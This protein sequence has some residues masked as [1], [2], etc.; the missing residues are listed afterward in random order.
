MRPHI[1]TQ[2]LYWLLLHSLA[3]F[4]FSVSVSDLS[5][6]GYGFSINFWQQKYNFSDKVLLWFLDSLVLL[7]ML[8]YFKNH[9]LRLIILQ[10]F[11]CSIFVPRMTRYWPY[12]IAKFMLFRHYIM[13]G[14]NQINLYQIDLKLRIIETEQIRGLWSVNTNLY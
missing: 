8:L 2:G 5:G 3:N 9:N 14:F 10:Y 11:T 7:F 6:H 13:I 12:Y 1:I 4:R